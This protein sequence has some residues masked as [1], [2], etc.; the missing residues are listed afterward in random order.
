MA[1]VSLKKGQSESFTAEDI[2][3]GAGWKTSTTKKK[4]F[5]GV[6][7]GG[8]KQKELDLDLLTGVLDDENDPIA[9]C[10]YGNED[11]W[12]DGSLKSKGDNQTGAGA[13]DDETHIVRLNEIPGNVDKLVFMV[14]AFKPGVSFL[15]VELANMNVYDGEGNKLFT[16]SVKINKD[17]NV[18][19]VA[20]AKR[21]S[22]GTWTIENLNEYGNVRPGDRDDLFRFMQQF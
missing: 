20:R 3:V 21:Q 17:A 19:A 16:I 22:D 12:D 11:V 9:V 14:S 7:V 4:R 6:Q 8:G 10:Y 13:G 2:S 15:D 18:I 5:L 1:V